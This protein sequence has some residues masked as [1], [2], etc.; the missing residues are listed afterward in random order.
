MATTPNT[1]V[2]LL[3]QSQ[4]QKEIT[5]NEALMR[6][7]TLLAGGA[8]DKDLATPP[9]SP[10]AGDV[11][12]VAASG[13]GAWS[14]KSGK[15]AYYDQGW[16]FIDPK[17]GML[18]W[19]KDE[20]QLY[21]YSGSSWM[22]LTT[23]GGGAADTRV[24]D[25]RLTLTSGTP[26]TT[27][28]VIAAGSVYF[29]PYKGNQIAL[30]DGTSTWTTLSFS[31]LTISLA[32]GFSSGKL[33][34]VF[35]Y[36]NAGVVALETVVWTNDTTRA[37]ALTLQNG[38]YV[39]SGATTWRY[40]GSFYT[41]SATTTEDSKAKRY[42]WNYQHRVVRELKRSET[43]TSWTYSTGAYRQANANSANQLDFIL[44]VAE[45][46]VSATLLVNASNST[47]TSR[48][49]FFGMMLDGTTTTD[50]EAGF[51]TTSAGFYA[52]QAISRHY[53]VAAGRHYIAWLEYGGGTDTQTWYGGDK[54]GLTGAV[55]A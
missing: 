54:R 24:C 3:E 31:Q 48:N 35:A 36:N 8:I 34:D 25:G 18:L 49:P 29:T 5:I 32:S 55:K 46:L 40:I 6:I 42:V 33:Y 22:V 50:C 9:G 47:S 16:K 19:L 12:I 28:D 51:V 10:T 53:T 14:G 20:D 23:G 17:E 21:Y 26:V 27:S 41:S 38:I 2:T 43:A 4:A 30:F 15:V 39:K 37:T 13:T 52:G 11:Y 44:G 45:D 1:G 7:D